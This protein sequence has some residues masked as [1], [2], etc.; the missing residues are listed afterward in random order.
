MIKV[1]DKINFV[2]KMTYLTVNKL[3]KDYYNGHLYKNSHTAIAL[4]INDDVLVNKKLKT[5]KALKNVVAAT[6]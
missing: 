5:I 2:N 1:A 3:F 4:K 6:I